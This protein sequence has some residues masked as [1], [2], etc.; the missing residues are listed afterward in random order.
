M[1]R[2]GDDFYVGA[3]AALIGGIK[4]G[5]R[6]V[7]GLNTTITEDVPDDTRIVSVAAQKVTRRSGS[8]TA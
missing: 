7:I 6:V 1:P 3:G 2:V 8:R 4:V 5:D